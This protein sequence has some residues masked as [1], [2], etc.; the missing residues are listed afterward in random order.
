MANDKIQFRIQYNFFLNKQNFPF[1]PNS[2][3]FSFFRSQDEIQ[4]FATNCILNPPGPRKPKQLNG[5][6]KVTKQRHVTPLEN[7]STAKRAR[8]NGN[9][10]AKPLGR[11]PRNK[12]K[13]LLQN[14]NTSQ[15]NE[16]DDASMQS[17][18]KSVLPTDIVQNGDAIELKSNETFNGGAML[19]GSSSIK[20]KVKY[21][22]P[23]QFLHIK[24]PPLNTQKIY[25]KQQNGNK[26]Y[27][28]GVK[29]IATTIDVKQPNILI[30][31][32]NIDQTAS[33]AVST[34]SS[35]NK[36]NVE[37]SNAQNQNHAQ[38]TA[39]DDINFFDIPI[40]FADKDGNIIDDNQTSSNEIS[41]TSATAQTINTID[42]ISKEIVNDTI[43][44]KEF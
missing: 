31:A 40:L 42:V 17:T 39:I 23:N 33:S 24:P 18:L 41:K 15:S 27:T 30:N 9:Q 36:T 10:R 1:H 2:F 8:M 20:Q 19:N 38:N 14:G 3:P 44:G 13:N 28:L 22:P 29:N 37:Y 26:S 25:V 43:I 21:I 16:M 11:P 5:C 12:A 6:R 34:S 7:G 35:P 32:K 4:E